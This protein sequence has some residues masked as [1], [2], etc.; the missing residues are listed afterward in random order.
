[1]GKSRYDKWVLCHYE[2]VVEIL[3]KI[4]HYMVINFEAETGVKCMLDRIRSM[5]LEI[6]EIGNLKFA[7]QGSGIC[8]RG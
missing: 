8:K 4:Q 5:A 7:I 3:V 2:K 6:N 1:M